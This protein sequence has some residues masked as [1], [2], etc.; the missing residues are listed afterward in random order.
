ME[1]SKHVY[2]YSKSC[3][4][5]AVENKEFLKFQRLI[6]PSRNPANNGRNQFE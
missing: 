5:T 6:M 1:K 4:Y 2:I 3:N